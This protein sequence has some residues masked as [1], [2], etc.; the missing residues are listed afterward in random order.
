MCPN[1]IYQHP[2]NW[3]VRE[4]VFP[5]GL[6]RLKSCSDYLVLSFQ[7]SLGVGSRGNFLELTSKK[8]QVL[9]SNLSCIR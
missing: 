1:Q 5:S 6:V 9:N 7:T 3:E 2:W 8:I 4:L